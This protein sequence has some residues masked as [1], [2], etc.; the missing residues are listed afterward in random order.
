MIKPDHVGRHWV[1]PG[2]D[3]APTS[4]RSVLLE[5]FKK[6]VPPGSCPD[7]TGGS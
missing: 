5:R 1:A 3:N 7:A 2:L 6:I 4:S